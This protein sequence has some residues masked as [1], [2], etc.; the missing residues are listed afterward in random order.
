MA[1]C[2]CKLPINQEKLWTTNTL[3]QNVPGDFH[4]PLSSY[5]HVS[6][7]YPYLIG[8]WRFHIDAA[9]DI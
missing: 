9:A 3:Q 4:A 6:K 8:G 7:T 2:P 5:T 1:A